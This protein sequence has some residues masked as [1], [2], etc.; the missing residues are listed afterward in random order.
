VCSI[1]ISCVSSDLMC[2]YHVLAEWSQLQL[3]D[4]SISEP[5][6]NI[7]SSVRRFGDNLYI[8]VPR[9]KSG[10]EFTLTS[11]NLLTG[12]LAPVLQPFP[13][14][15]LNK[16]GHCQAL[17][18]VDAIEIDPSGRLW[19]AD[20]GQTAPFSDPDRKCPPKLIIWDL[21]NNKELV[22]HLLPSPGQPLCLHQ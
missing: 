13:S 9:W 1:M 15:A 22:H 10:V 4:S 16:I 3:K 6:H 12:S 18:N 17:Q 14:H 2:D 11:L 8:S 5:Q 21:K 20:S 7:V 19:I